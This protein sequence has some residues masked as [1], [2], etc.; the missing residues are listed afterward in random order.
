MA[1]SVRPRP[2]LALRVA[3]LGTLVAV[4]A[5]A[6]QPIAPPTDIGARPAEEAKPAPSPPAERSPAAPAPP[7]ETE[8][9]PEQDA[10][11]TPAT[12][13]EPTPEVTP[14]TKPTAK[15]PAAPPKP[16]ARPLLK[17]DALEEPGYLPGYR[18]YQGLGL[19]PYVPRVGEFPG[20][21]TPSFGVPSPSDD[22]T[23]T[24]AGFMSASL[25]VSINEREDPQPG[26][27]KLVLHTS[28]DVVE[29]YASFLSTNA[30]PG[31]WIGATFSYGNSYVTATTS[32][33]TWN[34]ERAAISPGGQ[35]FIN[36]MFLRFRVPPIGKL[37]LAATV[38][39]F[40][41]SYGSLGRYGGGF[42][43][44]PMTGEIEGA[45]ET[46]VAEYDLSDNVILVAEHGI[47]GTDGPRIGFVPAEVVSGTGSGANQGDPQWPA[48]FVHHG[49]FGV[50]RKGE[51]QL[52]VQVHL[53]SNWAQDDR[54]QRTP[55]S[56]SDPQC[57]LETTRELDECYVKDG[58]IRVLG[59]DGKMLSRTW[60]VLG[61]GGAYIHSHYSDP[62]KGMKTFAGDGERLTS[63]WL[64]LGRSGTGKVWVAGLSYSLSVA[65]LMLSPEPF[66]GQAPD[67]TIDA[68][69]NIAH[70][71]S[72]DPIFDGRTRHKYGAKV[73]YTFSRYVGAGVRFD[74]VVPSSRKSA[75]T[76]HVLAPWVQ[77]KTDWTSHETISLS[78]VKWF[79]GRET[80][81]DGMNPTFAE[82]NTDDQMVALN[83]N[84]WW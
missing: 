76:F 42:Y 78:Y 83:F 50:V 69:V 45:G 3:L 59:I 20:A 38:G 81:V 46:I 68:G 21:V 43:T 77:F 26:Q 63:A 64:G 28:P 62:L 16:P 55:T 40:S 71:V 7:T 74:R 30:V 5:L 58:R 14:T 53:M 57:D 2:L 27:K 6:Q 70:S 51:T 82:E 47:T 56:P 80:H 33:N 32:I 72:D 37:R 44:N 41:N 4:P 13:P 61:I 65:S 34:P 31:N 54:V 18:T 10:A 73:T 60:G 79:L 15:P 52:Q 17:Y 36:D 75:Q 67:I 1:D 35:Y 22:W 39:Y 66:D 23:F 8:T 11:A 84:M 48:A 9:K 49:H 19:S 25:Q 12:N 29:E 24:Y